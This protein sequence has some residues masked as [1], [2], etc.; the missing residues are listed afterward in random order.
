MSYVI[1]TVFNVCQELSVAYCLAGEQVTSP[2]ALQS[3][4]QFQHLSFAAIDA[5]AKLVVLLLKVH[6]CLSRKC[7]SY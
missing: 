7:S 5:Y 6:A 4:Q 2:L 3:T 1:R